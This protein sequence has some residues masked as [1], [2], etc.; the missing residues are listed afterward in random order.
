MVSCK[1]RMPVSSLS[2]GSPLSCRCSGSFYLP[3]AGRDRGGEK[4]Y[5]GAYDSHGAQFVAGGLPLGSELRWP[6]PETP[7]GHSMSE[8]MVLPALQSVLLPEKTED[9]IDAGF[10]A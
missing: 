8:M 10:P 9:P 1:I 6:V 7:T 3:D 2:H 4:L 5:R